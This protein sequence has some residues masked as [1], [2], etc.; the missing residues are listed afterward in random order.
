MPIRRKWYGNSVLTKKSLAG[1]RDTSPPEP[2][3]CKWAGP[4]EITFMSNHPEADS[5]GGYARR[6]QRGD[7]CLCLMKGDE[8]A[9]YQWIAFESARALQEDIPG[10]EF[11]FLPLTRTSAYLYDLYVYR[12]HRG[13]RLGPLIRV[14]S[15]ASLKELGYR[16]IF[17]LVDIHNESGL[18]V[19]THTDEELQRLA[20]CY[21]VGPWKKCFFGPLGDPALK[22]WW[23]DFHARAK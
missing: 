12:Q 13:K 17:A 8:L 16:E 7:R 19:R 18:R 5:R 2:Y 21:R 1:V 23:D 20:Y 22:K 11:R 15:F 4:A 3:R 14:Q 6:V 9:G 10:W